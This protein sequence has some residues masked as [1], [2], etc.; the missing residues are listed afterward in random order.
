MTGNIVNTLTDYENDILM[1]WFGISYVKNMTHRECIKFW[2]NLWFCKQKNIDDEL[3]Q[4]FEYL[5]EKQ[6]AIN[7]NN[8]YSKIAHLILYDQISRNI[9]RNTQ[10]AYM[11]DNIAISIIENL[12]STMGIDKIMLVNIQFIIHIILC[13]AHSENKDIH[14]VLKKIMDLFMEKFERDYYTICSTLKQ[15]V[16]NHTL[17]IEMFGRIPERNGF[18]GRESTKEEL[19]F[20]NAV[21]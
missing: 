3:R 1:H 9:F 15:I 20:M 6:L 16:E 4:K 14:I 10:K 18:I 12:V 13:M 2:N 21:K 8:F 7:Q 5:Y 11:Y 19:A 17:R